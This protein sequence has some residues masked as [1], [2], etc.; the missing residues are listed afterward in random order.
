MARICIRIWIQSKVSI[1]CCTSEFYYSHWTFLINSSGNLLLNYL[2]VYFSMNI[3]LSHLYGW[4]KKKWAFCFKLF[5]RFPNGECHNVREG[6]L[7]ESRKRTLTL[8]FSGG[9]KMKVIMTWSMPRDRRG[10]KWTRPT[11]LGEVPGTWKM[12]SGP[13][14]EGSS[15]TSRI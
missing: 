8:R 7:E 4:R 14:G 11:V 15:L 9:P 10:N 3:L 6:E 5:H 13:L 1:A 2:Y 12:S